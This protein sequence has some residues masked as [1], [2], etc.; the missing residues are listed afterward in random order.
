MLLLQ[1]VIIA[2]NGEAQHTALAHPPSID[3]KHELATLL[4][5]PP[6]TLKQEG[7]DDVF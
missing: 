1:P 6:I 5:P 3:E 4:Q 2:L 7:C